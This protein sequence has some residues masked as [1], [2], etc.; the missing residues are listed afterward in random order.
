MSKKVRTVL[1]FL[2]F[3]VVAGILMSDRFQDISD[4][5]P[6]SAYYWAFIVTLAGLT[7]LGLYA[8]WQNYNGRKMDPTVH[9][10]K[11]WIERPSWWNWPF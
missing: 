7:V 4:T 3:F 11:K 8:W 6:E 1:S 2:G 10:V 5:V 9:R